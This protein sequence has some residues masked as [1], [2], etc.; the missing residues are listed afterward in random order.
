MICISCATQKN[1]LPQRWAVKWY[2]IL[3]SSGIFWQTESN[4]TSNEVGTWHIPLSQYSLTRKHVSSLH[5][6]LPKWLT[7]WQ[8]SDKSICMQMTLPLWT[9]LSTMMS[10]MHGRQEANLTTPCAFNTFRLSQSTCL[11]ILELGLCSLTPGEQWKWWGAGSYISVDD[12]HWPHWKEFELLLPNEDELL[13]KSYPILTISLF[14][15][16]VPWKKVCSHYL[17]HNWLTVGSFWC[18]AD[19]QNSLTY[20]QPSVKQQKKSFLFRYKYWIIMLKKRDLKPLPN[21]KDSSSSWGIQKQLVR[22]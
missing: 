17:V 15:L 13:T 10:W 22:E 18:V 2:I 1:T 9:S 7:S 8:P 20:G 4:V 16:I 19:S 12:F 21:P 3:W 11:W 5:L 14:K 6:L